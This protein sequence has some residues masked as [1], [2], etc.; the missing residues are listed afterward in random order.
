MNIYNNSYRY[1]WNNIEAALLSDCSSNIY[2]YRECIDILNY[3]IDKY[4]NICEDSSLKL[5]ILLNTKGQNRLCCELI[6]CY[7]DEYCNKKIRVLFESKDILNILE[8]LEV[9]TNILKQDVINLKPIFNFHE[10]NYISFS[11]A[12]MICLK[13]KFINIALREADNKTIETG[14][15][16]HCLIMKLYHYIYEELNVTPEIR[17]LNNNK[18]YLYTEQI[19]GHIKKINNLF[20]Y[21]GINYWSKDNNNFIHVYTIEDI[22]ATKNMLKLKNI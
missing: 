15:S 20:K 9:N 16:I 19:K 8:L 1:R 12:K 2:N 18:I 13:P 22:E 7:E 14:I 10:R 11:K 17:Y 5:N 21:I 6:D 4:I 3:I